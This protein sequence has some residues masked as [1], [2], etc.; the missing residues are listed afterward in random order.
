MV[1]DR[2]WR[3]ARPAQLLGKPMSL[4]LK[5]VESWLTPIYPEHIMVYSSS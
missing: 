4:N 5:P 3:Q 2:E 1:S